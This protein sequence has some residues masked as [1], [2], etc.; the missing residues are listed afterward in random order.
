MD[1]TK[2]RAIV[3]TTVPVTLE[4]FQSELIQQLQHEYEVVL[5]SSPDSALGRVAAGFDVS[6]YAVEM[7]RTISP[8]RDAVAVLNFLR[9]LRHVRP[10]LVVAATPKASL[11]AL[12]ASRLTRVPSRLYIVYGF[13]FEGSHGLHRH[14]LILME[15]I[16]GLL[17]TSII[18]ISPSLAEAARRLTLYP[19]G[20]VS[21]THPASSHGVNCTNFRPLPAS[22]SLRS[23]LGL[24]DS[25]PVIGFAGRLTHDKG[26]DTLILSVDELERRGVRMQL[27]V[28]SG[29]DEPD[30][31]FYL[32]RLRHM[33]THVAIVQ[34]VRPADM[35]QYYNLMDVH[36][37]PSLREGFPNVVLEASASGVPTVTTLA[38]GCRDSV[39]PGKTGLLVPVR[40]W[41]ALAD[42]LQELLQNPTLRRRMGDAARTWVESEFQPRKVVASLLRPILN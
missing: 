34:R 25:L 11:L 14:V 28:I 31:E 2:P 13:R 41:R 38:T 39:L 19:N 20:R 37:L 8:R 15:R 36:V 5:V 6:Y 22:E 7:T 9:I 18:T 3:T 32:D 1:P 17:A 27:L 10:T 24:N 23:E 26:L 12:V 40:D 4:T 16:S 35:P 30:S 29:G 33:R 42:S 21:S